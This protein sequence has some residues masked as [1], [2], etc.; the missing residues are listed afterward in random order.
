MSSWGEEGLKTRWMERKQGRQAREDVEMAE[1]VVREGLRL[2]LSA[3]TW[4]AIAT[5]ERFP[6]TRSGCSTSFHA[7][8]PEKPR[9]KR[10][11]PGSIS[12]FVSF[13]R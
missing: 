5:P 6:E 1:V 9:S 4:E 11:G 3:L 13:A 7:S 2:G 8:A 10:C 12:G